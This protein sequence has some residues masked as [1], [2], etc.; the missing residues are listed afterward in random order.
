M[1]NRVIAMA[2]LM[3]MV[4]APSA[5]AQRVE[6]SGLFGWTLSDGVSG[7]PVLAGDGNIYE[8]V[9]KTDTAS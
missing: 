5:F 7:D 2:A 9:D 6:V 4:G 3:L 8:E 1:W